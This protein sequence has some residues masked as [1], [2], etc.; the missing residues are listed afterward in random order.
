ML[1]AEHQMQ[2]SMQGVSAAKGS[3]ELRIKKQQ[4][5]MTYSCVTC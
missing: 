4:D 3:L 2:A 1:T 5:H